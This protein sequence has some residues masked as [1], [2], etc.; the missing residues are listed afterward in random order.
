MHKSALQQ[1]PTPTLWLRKLNNN[2]SRYIPRAPLTVKG[3]F[4]AV[5]VGLGNTC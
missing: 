2:S 5:L 1:S 3:A 4:E